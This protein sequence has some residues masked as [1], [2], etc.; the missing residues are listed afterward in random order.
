VGL[1]DSGFYGEGLTGSGLGQ[2]G[3]DVAP[4]WHGIVSHG[5]TCSPRN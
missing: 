3:M 4:A 2:L 5:G 1:P